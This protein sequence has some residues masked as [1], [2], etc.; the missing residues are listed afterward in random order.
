MLVSERVVVGGKEVSV[1]GR[2][3]Y[4]FTEPSFLFLEHDGL[5]SVIFKLFYN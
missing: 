3:I 4:I 5:R 2:A 1:R